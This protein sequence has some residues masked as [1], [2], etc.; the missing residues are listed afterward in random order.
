[1]IYNSLQLTVIQLLPVWRFLIFMI[2]NTVEEKWLQEKWGKFGA[3]DM[4]KLWSKGKG[5]MFGE[6]AKTH[7][8][9]VA[10]QAYT[11]FNTCDSVET[12]A[13]KMGKVNEP[14]SF[15]YLYNLLGIPNLQY[16]GSGN[17]IFLP[18]IENDF[19]TDTGCSPDSCAITKDNRISFGMEFKNPSGDTHWD[20]LTDIT[21]QNSLKTVC[22][23]FY[24]QI[25]FSM[26]CTGTDLWLWCSYNEYFPEK[27]KALIIE[28]TP[29]KEFMGELNE[30]ILKA[31]E[32]KYELIEEMK[33]KQ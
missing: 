1:V 20:Y 5:E 2:D 21:D 22:K 31:I 19:K 4:H 26:A 29:D 27:H 25:Q 18:H 17:P 15:G 24:T 33:N 10:R 12:Y 32:K 30:R 13:M 23:D 3:S 7:I 16:Y 28:C 14:Q 6:G 11:M 9:K 8:K